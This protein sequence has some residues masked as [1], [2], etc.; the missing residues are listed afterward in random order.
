MKLKEFFNDVR[1]ENGFA[2]QIEVSA[3]SLKIEKCVSGCMFFCFE[4][5]YGASLCCSAEAVKRGALVVVSEQKIEAEFLKNADCDFCSDNTKKQCAVNLVVQNARDFLTEACKVFYGNPQ[6]KLKTIA[7]VGTNGKTTVCSLVKKLLS[8]SNIPCGAIGTF[9]AVYGENKIRTGMT[10]PD[11]PELYEIMADMVKC[12]MK[13]VCMELSAHAIFYKRADFSFDAVV[14]TNCSPEHLDFFKTYEKYR[15]TKISAFSVQKARIAVINSDDDCYALIQ[16]FRKKERGVISYGIK[17]PSDVF[18]I[19]VRQKTDGAEFIINLFDAVYRIKSSLIGK[20]NVYNMLAAATVCALFGVK[21]ADIAKLLSEFMPVCGRMERVCLKKRVYVDYAHTPDALK[22]ALITLR[23]IKGAGRLICVFGCGGNR[24]EQKREKMGEISGRYAD[25]TV[26][27]SDNP[28]YEE[29]FKII[30][31]IE[32]GIR[33]SSLNYIVIGEREQAIKYAVGIA[34]ENDVILI[35][36]KGAEEY[37]EVM[38]T[39]RKFSDKEV[40]CA[41]LNGEDE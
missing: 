21:T 37:Q 39:F 9:G 5:D 29:P 26:I 12:G 25:F 15:D 6:K 32:S 11:A 14:F 40:A 41:F 27:T 4:K 19:D 16:G 1:F 2:A 24:D 28:R 20:F 17:N 3:I 18:A 8:D 31:Q 36:G 23:E 38:G 7:V 13:A 22:N 35:A 30:S 10:T 33:K 34:G